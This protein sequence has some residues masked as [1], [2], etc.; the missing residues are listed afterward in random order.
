MRRRCEVQRRA[1]RV[2]MVVGW[3][4]LHAAVV[5]PAM[6]I[7]WVY[8]SYTSRL[9]R[10][11]FFTILS[12]QHIRATSVAWCAILALSGL[13]VALVRIHKRRALVLP[14]IVLAFAA[15]SGVQFS[16]QSFELLYVTALQLS[17]LVDA[18]PWVQPLVTERRLLGAVLA[19]AA[20]LTWLF[21]WP[22]TPRR[23]QDRRLCPNCG[24][25]VAG[26]TLGVCPE[27]GTAVATETAA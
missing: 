10:T 19:V 24:Y 22:F 17:G 8:T 4:T 1:D 23:P 25:T 27:C 14:G 21:V 26:L 20:L 16:I 15:F 2:A 13:H 6:L 9:D 18:I 3:L 12:L 11:S 7:A 5:V